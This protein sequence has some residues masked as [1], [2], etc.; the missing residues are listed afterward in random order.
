[1]G[2]VQPPLT[3]PIRGLSFSKG[4]STVEFG[5]LKTVVVKDM[6]EFSERL[7]RAGKP[8]SPPPTITIPMIPAAQDNRPD[9]VPASIVPD[10]EKRSSGFDMDDLMKY[11]PYAIGG[12]LLILILKRSSK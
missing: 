9:P 2:F 1:M 10:A 12:V 7:K 5:P 8:F 6:L 4:N 3:A 11:A